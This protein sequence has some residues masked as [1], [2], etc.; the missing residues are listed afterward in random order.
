MIE[1]M[2]FLG[3]FIAWFAFVLF[4]A[5]YLVE[6]GQITVKVMLGVSAF[7]LT[8]WLLSVVIESEKNNPCLEYE[9]T[10]MYNAAVKAMMPVRSCKKR[11]EW[12]KEQQQ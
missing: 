7:V 11:G 12:V 10:M 9:A 4:T 8:S 2:M 1:A 6:G 3:S 5:W